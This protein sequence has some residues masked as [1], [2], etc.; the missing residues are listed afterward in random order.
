MSC[1]VGVQQARYVMDLPDESTAAIG[2]VPWGSVQVRK[3]VIA[4]ATL[5]RLVLTPVV[6]VWP[7]MTPVT[8]LSLDVLTVVRTV[9]PCVNADEQTVLGLYRDALQV[10][11]GEIHDALVR[12]R[13]GLCALPL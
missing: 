3:R 8:S 11:Y 6:R 2:G 4:A 12:L 7:A 5:V 1:V 13:D 9:R 10:G